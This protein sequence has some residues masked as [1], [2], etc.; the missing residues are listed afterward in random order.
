MVLWHHLIERRRDDESRVPTLAGAH[1]AGGDDLPG[2]RLR[3]RGR[4]AAASAKFFGDASGDHALDTLQALREVGAHVSVELLEKAL[5]ALPRGGVPRP[6]GR[7]GSRTS[8]GSTPNARRPST[9]LDE[10][11]SRARRLPGREPGREGR[12]PA[13][14]VPQAARGHPPEIL[15][16]PARWPAESALIPTPRGTT[17]MAEATSDAFLSGQ[18][19][20]VEPGPDRVGADPALGAGRRARRGART[21]R[22]PTSPGSSWPTWSSRPGRTARS[23]WRRRST[24]SSSGTPAGRSCCGGPTS[25]AGGSPPRSPRSATSPRPTGRRS[26]PS[27][28]SSGPGPEALDLLPGAV[29][30]LLEA[31]LPFVLWWTERPPA[32]P[33]RCSATSPAN[34]RG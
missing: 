16:R 27:G 11:Y 25:R 1:P 8:A 14:A 20:P 23:A 29:R 32:R 30:P 4:P 2:R 26:A 13:P 34:A 7:P 33:S 21:W 24:P 15:T 17:V 6:T 12:R 18:G 10:L 31:N 19:I 5:G 22:T 3:G 9:P 28:S